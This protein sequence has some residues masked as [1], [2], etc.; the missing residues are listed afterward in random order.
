MLFDDVEEGWQGRTF[1]HTTVGR[2]SGSSALRRV[3]RPR[4]RRSTPRAPFGK[5]VVVACEA[6]YVR[7]ERRRTGVRVRR[8]GPLSIERVCTKQKHQVWEPSQ[9]GPDAEGR[10]RRPQ[11]DQ[12]KTKKLRPDGHK[13]CDGGAHALHHVLLTAHF[14]G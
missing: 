12:S 10:K 9:S 2:Q 7:N 11:G 8:P 14:V 5:G 1:S 3:A 13:V 4:L 6:L